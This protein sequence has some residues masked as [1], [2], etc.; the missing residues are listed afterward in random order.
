MGLSGVRAEWRYAVGEGVKGGGDADRPLASVAP[1]GEWEYGTLIMGGR[2]DKGTCFGVPFRRSSLL[3][4][5]KPLLHYRQTGAKAIPKDV[6]AGPFRQMD[7]R[8]R[9]A[10]CRRCGRGAQNVVAERFSGTNAGVIPASLGVTHQCRGSGR[11]LPRRT[12]RRSRQMASP[13][14]NGVS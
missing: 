5:G 12:A 1:P 13:V 11:A 9:P 3:E 14:R 10:V 2:G 4:K 6:P 7:C 8:G